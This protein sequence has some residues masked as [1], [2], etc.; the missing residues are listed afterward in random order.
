MEILILKSKDAVATLG[1][2]IMAEQVRGNPNTVLGLATGES[3]LAL[4][5]KLVAMYQDSG[6]SYRGVTTFNLDEYLGVDA[7]HPHSYRHYMQEQL[8]GRIDIDASNTHLPVCPDDQDPW[9]TAAAYESAIHEAG[10]IDLQLLGIGRNGHIGFNEP[11]S[12]LASR[13]RVKTLAE[14]T[15][16]DNCD[17]FPE[18]EPQPELAMTMGIGTILEARDI[19]VIATGAHKATAVRQAI[20]GPVSASCPAS[21]LQLHPS[22]TILLDTGAA[23][24]L[25]LT[26]YYKATSEHQASLLQRWSRKAGQP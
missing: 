18:G 13:T 4:Y 8:F 17:W 6:P 5:D 12:S 3:P 23:S 10:G 1:A 22:V 21:A 26:P 9:S 2:S 11:T 25:E 19:L 14:D 15:I 7:A 20:E 24:E 16:R